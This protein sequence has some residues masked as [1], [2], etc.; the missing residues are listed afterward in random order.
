VTPK[1]P[2]VIPLRDEESN[3]APSFAELT[4]PL[5]H[6]INRTIETTEGVRTHE[7]VQTA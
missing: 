1:I 5:S 2:L 4:V 6:E 3:V 7:V